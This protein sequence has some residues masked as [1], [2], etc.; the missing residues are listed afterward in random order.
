MY[1]VNLADTELALGDIPSAIDAA[2]RSVD[3]ADKS[4][5]EDL[6]LLFR[7]EHAHARAAAGEIARAQA[8]FADADADA[9]QKKR[10]PEYPRLY[11]LA[12]AHFCDLLLGEG[13]LKEVADRGAYALALAERENW[14]LDIG[15]ENSSLG[16]A[17]L[18]LALTAP[19][20]GDAA[21]HLAA[22]GKHLDIAVAELG[23]SSQATH[24]P[25]GHL[26]RARLRRAEGDFAGAKRDLDEVLEIAEPGPMRLHLCD[27]HL[28]LCRLA[29]AQRDGFAPLSPSPPPAA[30]GEARDKLTQTARDELG[31]ASKLIR[32]CGYHKRDAER[33]ELNQ[34]LDGKR[35]F[36]DLPIH[37]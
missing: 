10:Q 21:A 5:D 6:M 11:S 30:T 33:D 3:F 12:G 25:L 36:C 7:A 26:A 9:R 24:V 28:E 2:A 32:A 18:G 17:A 20:P 13:R 29:L 15:L 23:R 27:M 34:V 8:L 31:E 1:A 19:T 16:R 22:A 14:V 35:L 37:V 4:A